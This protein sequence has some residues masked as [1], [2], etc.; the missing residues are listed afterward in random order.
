MESPFRFRTPDDGLDGAS[1]GTDGLSIADGTEA[2]D[3]PW[4]LGWN[5][6][7]ETGV[8]ELFEEQSSVNA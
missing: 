1:I 7:S 2:D 8:P 4:R 6:D 3:K 5:G